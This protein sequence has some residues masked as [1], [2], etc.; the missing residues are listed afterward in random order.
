MRVSLCG[1]E[2]QSMD[3]LAINI[4][5]AMTQHKRIIDIGYKYRL[6]F[7]VFIIFCWFIGFNKK[8]FQSGVFFPNFVIWKKLQNF[9]KNRR[10]RQ[11][12]IFPMF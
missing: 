6:M 3:W 8:L 2:V 5:S 9:Q 7:P 11:A 12:K 1:S 4:W 10:I